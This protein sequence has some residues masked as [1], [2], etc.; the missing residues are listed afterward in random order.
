MKKTVSLLLII[1]ATFT[2]F[3]CQ[4]ELDEITTIT[5]PPG[6][7]GG[8]DGSD[9]ANAIVG[10]WN[11]VSMHAETESST[12][13]LLPNVNQKT[14]AQLNYTTINNAGVV[15]ITD[16]V[17]NSSGL[18]YTISSLIKTYTYQDSVLTDSG[19]APV[20]ITFPESATS[21]PY[22]L[23]GTDS[24]YFP[25]GGFTNIAAAKFKTNQNVAA[26]KLRGDTLTFNQNIYKDSIQTTS[27]IDYH[28]IQTGTAIIT[29][30]KKK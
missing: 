27:G 29:L 24:I 1:A 14:I 8:N 30:V 9:T 4:K 6:D 21:S 18:T 12:E 2:L 17:M 5:P 7:D 3:S 16:S 13:L 22:K 23:I 28:I 10:T 15:V 25:K 20:N 26:I 11:F 19:Q